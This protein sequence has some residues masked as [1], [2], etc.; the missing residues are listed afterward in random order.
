M[1]TLTLD[2]FHSLDVDQR[3]SIGR[4]LTD[5]GVALSDVVELTFTPATDDD[6]SCLLV[7]RHELRVP[8]GQ[9]LQLLLIDVP[10]PPALRWWSSPSLDADETADV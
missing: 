3:S 6:P 5:L 9:E 2:R 1:H 4:Y 10:E 7:E 8:T